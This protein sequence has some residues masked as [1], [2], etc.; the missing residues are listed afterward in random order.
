MHRSRLQVDYRGVMFEGRDDGTVVTVWAVP[1][2]SKDEIVGPHGDMLKVR[3]AAPR[4]GGKAN[5]AIERLLA[6][7]IGAD[8]RLVAGGT[9][10][11]K[12]FLLDG[13]TPAEAR[14]RLL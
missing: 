14:R 11:A 13:V 8:V 1:G 12:R 3:I 6:D 10:R 2:A 4:E 9:G 7:R 5:R